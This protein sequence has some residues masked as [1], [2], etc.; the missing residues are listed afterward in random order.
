MPRGPFGFPRVTNVGPFV[1]E[2]VSQRFVRDNKGS[3][4]H[5]FPEDREIIKVFNVDEA[6]IVTIK[7]RLE[8]DK[9]SEADEA[10]GIVDTL[11]EEMEDLRFPT[12]VAHIRYWYSQE[13][14]V[15]KVEGTVT[16]EDFTRMGIA[17]TLRQ[18]ELEHLK[19]LGIDFVF[20]DVVSDGGYN[21]AKSTGAKPIDEMARDTGHLEFD[22]ELNR[23]IMF[24]RL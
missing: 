20:T 8:V 15:A 17:K 16:E 14:R 13:S 22:H 24:N 4:T 1:D 2:D 23:G 9:E 10:D 5:I 12:E 21:L 19:D 6:S 11:M 3:K 18:K 7:S